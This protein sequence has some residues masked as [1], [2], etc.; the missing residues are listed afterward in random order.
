MTIDIHS[1]CILCQRT[2]SSSSSFKKVIDFIL[3]YTIGIYHLCRQTF[4]TYQKHHKQF[5]INNVIPGDK[6]EKLIFIITG[7]TSG[8]GL[9]IFTQLEKLTNIEIIKLSQKQSQQKQTTNI[10]E[11]IFDLNDI[12]STNQV[13]EKLKKQFFLENSTSKIIFIHCAGIYVPTL[14]YKTIKV[15]TLMPLI[16][17][18]SLRQYITSLLILGSASYSI[19]PSLTSHCPLKYISSFSSY[20]ISKALLFSTIQYLKIS[21]K[22][23]R[24]IIIVHPGVVNTKL[25]SGQRG[26][27][28][29]I[30]RWVVQMFA[31]SPR[32]SAE[33]VLEV[34]KVSGLLLDVDDCDEGLYWDAVTMKTERVPD[35]FKFDYMENTVQFMLK[36]LGIHQ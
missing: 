4:L 1:S 11:I 9:E 32:Y 5:D 26:L 35:R 21:S 15:N 16:L 17:L 13:I 30:L 31:W 28:G 8:I 24:K 20:P 2:H 14:P 25:Y 33:R 27:L 34:M 18:F 29:N 10:H 19:S 12:N 23:L 22:K 7:A 36:S 6:N 3:L